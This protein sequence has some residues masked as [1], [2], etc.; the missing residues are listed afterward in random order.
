MK[1]REKRV[2]IKKKIKSRKNDEAAI[3]MTIVEQDYDFG[4]MNIMYAFGVKC[5]LIVMKTFAP[6]FSPFDFTM[7]HNHSA[8][9]ILPN[10]L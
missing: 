2:L 10:N 3:M 4:C 7:P 6:S 9:N 5:V 1:N 8:A